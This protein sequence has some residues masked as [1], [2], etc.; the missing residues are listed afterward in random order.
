MAN[1]S[2]TGSA[3]RPPANDMAQDA[4]WSELWASQGATHRR[5]ASLWNWLRKRRRQEA[6]KTWRR[7]LGRTGL[8]EGDLLEI[9]CAPGATMEIVHE[10]CPRFRLHGV[11][12]SQVGLENT[13]H[14]LAQLG[15]AAELHFGDVFQVE[16]PQQ[17][18]VVMSAGVIEHFVD[19]LSIVQHHVRLCKPGGVVV[20]TV[21]HLR[22]PVFLP[23]LRRFDPETLAVHNLQTVR[24]ET[25]QTLFTQA[26][27]QHIQTGKS[28]PPRLHS[29]AAKGKSFGRAYEILTRS[30]NLVVE[31]IPVNPLWR[32]HLWIIGQVPK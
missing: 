28:G 11:D 32:S 4:Y 22:T 2:L 18:D 13:R 20:V 14:R 5:P 31:S 30:W 6:A 19:P 17:Y 3:D 21:P 27:L 16:L 10:A 1:S 23:L 7:L 15:I 24:R 12:Y 8:S 26:G 25:L 9:G 29:T